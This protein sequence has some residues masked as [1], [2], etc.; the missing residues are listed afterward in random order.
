MTKSDGAEH[1]WLPGDDNGPSLSPLRRQSQRQ[2][3]KEDDATPMTVASEQE[4]G[5]HEKFLDVSLEP[6]KIL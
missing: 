5:Y 6:C 2:D 1:L 3:D 4:L